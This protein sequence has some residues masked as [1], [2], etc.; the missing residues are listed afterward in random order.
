[1]DGKLNKSHD[2]MDDF[3]EN[4]IQG[5]Y[6]FTNKTVPINCNSSSFPK[7]KQIHNQP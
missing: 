6:I 3:T 4:S 1:M 2:D 5:D 7:E